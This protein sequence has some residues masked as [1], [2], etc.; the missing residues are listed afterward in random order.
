M[1]ASPRKAVYVALG[2]HR[3]R[4]AERHTAELVAA[5]AQVVL[6]APDLPEWANL[7]LPA[8]VPVH[9]VDA[10]DARTTSR[11]ARRL[12]RDRNGPLRDADLLVVGDPY[13]FPVA[14]D[15]AARRGDLAVALEPTL[16]PGRRPA[17]A[18][19]AVVTPWYPSANNAL[20][21]A[22]V[23]ATIGAVRADH[24]RISVLHTEDWPYRYDSPDAEAI[25]VA[26][27]R[28]TER[29]IR[30]ATRDTV[31]GEVTRVP[32][33]ISSRRDYA[34]WA[35]GH[36]KAM[37]QALPTGQIEAPLV[38]A[39]TG[40]YGG[41]VAQRLA[42]Q[43]ARVVITEHASFLGQIFKQPAARRLYDEA[44]HRA[45]VFLC[46]SRHLHDEVLDEFPHHAH[47]LRVVPNAIDFGD[48]APR[49]E[50]PRDLLRWLYV[51]RLSEQK[52][53]H[54]LLSA[55]LA[56]AAEEPR[57]T[58]TLVGA[59]PLVDQIRAEIERSDHGDRIDLRPAVAPSEVAELMRTHDLLVH[60][61][62]AETFGMTVVEAVACGTPVLVARSQ[63]PQETLSGLNGRAGL[64][65]D[66]SED[67]AV[68]VEGFRELRKR[69]DEL[70]LPAARA[71][72]IERYGRDAVAAQLREVYRGPESSGADVVAA[73]ATAAAPAAPTAPSRVVDPDAP[74]V[75]LVAI[76]PPQFK[77]VREYVHR[78]LDRGY[79]VDLITND[80]G[81][82][83]RSEVDEQVRL[84]PLNVA[85]R[86]RPVL[87]AEQLFVYRAPG[88]ALSVARKRASRSEVLWPELFV[89]RLERTHGSAA[90]WFH[91]SVFYP[92]YRVVRPRVLWRIVQR[93]VLPKLDLSR[94][95][96]IV[97]AGVFGVT[98]GWQLGRQ[99]SDLTVTTSLVPPEPRP[100]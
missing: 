82:W 3:V 75:V 70:D 18:D 69:M 6:V 67:P 96:R 83:R 99:R 30:P 79:G 51:G 14:W 44:L 20:A 88:K 57:A 46:V 10:A 81:Q 37:R 59:G 45:D 77:L 8:G 48:F 32:V 91:T 100:L 7:D 5:G 65:V 47:K 43:D 86:R 34:A 62:P 84:L 94:T 28:L 74:R 1:S 68:V 53:V 52:G 64:L 41:V 12:L 66:V 36:V 50:P 26:A 42:R 89:S 72:L 95:E 24:P 56:V 71:A 63:G 60:A 54:T 11:A 87:W 29:A 31:A 13:A 23:E 33:P 80:P 21:G 73:P 22:F 9:R 78:L 4:A 15:A 38:H 58:L 35:L 27:G 16:D 19:L 98:I 97:V 17:P 25:S 85:E 90:R 55:F 93:D 49:V 2:P 39:H 92:G 40:I 61:S 76:S